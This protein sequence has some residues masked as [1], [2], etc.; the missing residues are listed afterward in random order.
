MKAKSG[1][2]AE[3]GASCQLLAQT[4]GDE[5]NGGGA[6]DQEHERGAPTD[7]LG[8]GG[9]LGDFAVGSADDQRRQRDDARD[10]RLHPFAL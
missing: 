8:V 2:R 1:A 6:R 5:S 3:V 10:A 9:G 4:L 7:D